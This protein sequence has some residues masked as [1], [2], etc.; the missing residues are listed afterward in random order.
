MIDPALLCV[1]S[2]PD[3]SLIQPYFLF[4]YYIH[5][6]TILISLVIGIYIYRRN[7][8]SRTNQLLLFV[9]LIF[10]IWALMSLINAITNNSGIV[11]F[12]W[13]T[14]ITIEPL[15]YIGCLFLVSIFPEKNKISSTILIFSTLIYLP[16]LV[17]SIE[18]KLLLGINLSACLALE[19][20]LSTYS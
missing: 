5:I 2:T 20:P 11:L 15:I 3:S 14:E 7:I 12:T 13:S 19:S 1:I 4:H 10:S 18:N 9:I 17:L 6:P 16:L 8:K